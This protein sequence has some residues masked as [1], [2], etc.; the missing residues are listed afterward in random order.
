ME[1]NSNLAAFKIE[2]R[3]VS[4]AVFLEE[5]LDFTDSR[6]LPSVYDKASESAARYVDWIIRTF[7]IDSAAV[8]SLRSDP[9]TWKSK[10][11]VEVISQLRA[12]GIPVFEV[13]KA[14]LLGSFAH[15]P[16]RYRTE[17]RTIVELIWPIL[18]T[19]DKTVGCIDAAALG[20]HVQVE[21]MFALS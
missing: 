8:E 13:D 11:T 5:R 18:S 7:Q 16:L 2:R 20:L 6:Q 10:L 1:M 12:L 9:A 4:A 21:K 3:R 14:A 19:K 17:L 15:P